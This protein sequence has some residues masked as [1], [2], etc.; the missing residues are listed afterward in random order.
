MHQL[1]ARLR[2][3]AVATAFLAFAATATPAGL[4]TS[5]SIGRYDFAYLPQGDARVKPLQVFDDGEKTYFQFRTDGPVPAI[6]AGYGREMLLP[7]RDGPYVVVAARP[8]EFTL[9]L[10][11][12]QATVVHADVAAGAQ[13]RIGD[14][15]GDSVLSHPG[16]LQ[17]A[18]YDAGNAM[19]SSYATPLRGDVIAW[20]DT[21]R[22]VEQPVLFAEG[23]A[24][25][26]KSVRSALPRLAARIGP[27]TQVTVIGRD[28]ASL[29][30]DLAQKR[31]SELRKALIA[32]GVPSANIRTQVGV[33]VGDPVSSGG[34]MLWA[35]TI[36]WNAPAPREQTAE[37]YLPQPTSES[38]RG[39]V[40][41]AVPTTPKF[42]LKADDGTI[43]AAMQ[44]WAKASGYE[45]VWD[46]MEVKLTGTSTVQAGDFLAAVKR[47]VGDLQKLNY[48][49]S[50]QL[51][52]DRVVRIYVK[53]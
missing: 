51:Y 44:R 53:N 22:S 23:S 27:D 25:L 28:D 49:V 18:R 32:E 52:S 21:G 19:Q 45:L 34:K 8:R 39:Q 40:A 26:S 2:N 46:A 11:L 36:R 50:P 3:V 17:P 38:Q 15:R 1:L 14:P 43:G 30:E 41:V 5:A 6:F 4:Q 47:V 31:A 16:L 35:S 37:R 29:K 48:P 9:A 13:P 42:E 20:Q 10:G 7:Y 12:A 24:A 33:E